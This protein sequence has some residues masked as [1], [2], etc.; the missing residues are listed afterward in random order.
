MKIYKYIAN[1]DK[2]DSLILKNTNYDYLRSLFIS[3]EKIGALDESIIGEE[4][5]VGKKGDF[6]RP[7]TYIPVFS[8]KA[9]QVLKEYLKD[10]VEFFP[11]SN[12]PEY[13]LVNILDMDDYVDFEKSNLVRNPVTNRVSRVYS[14]VFLESAY[15]KEPAIFADRNIRGI[16]IYFNDAF[17][18]IVKKHKLKGLHIKEPIG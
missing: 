2:F 13:Y 9:V 10:T 7:D 4:F 15:K 18:E 11:F 5:I 16:D 17:L 3:G 12:I 6:T 14:Y 1:T 8:K